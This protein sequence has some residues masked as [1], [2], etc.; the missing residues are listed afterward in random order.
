MSQQE[1]VSPSQSQQS[2][3]EHE[4][5]DNETYHPQHPYYWS[6]N[7][8]G[9]PRD[10]PPSSYDEPMVQ[11]GYQAQDRTEDSKRQQGTTH[12]SRILVPARGYLSPRQGASTFSNDP[13]HDDVVVPLAGTR[14]RQAQRQ[15]FGP[16]GDAYERGYGMDHRYN[17]GRNV[18]PWARAQPK[19][20]NVARLVLFIALGLMLIGPILHLLA[21]LL[22]LVI[23][24]V[25]FA[26]LLAFFVMMII[27]ILSFIF[28]VP[29]RRRSSF[30]PWLGPLGW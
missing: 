18:P 1:F 27:G 16:D 9:V 10:E 13:R 26:L 19:Q 6:P 21:G 11:R 20:K 29:L 24:T 8:A 25:F 12:R 4:L 14:E 22:I 2:Q 7:K 15:Q 28:R 23:G 3:G 5:N 30:P 17:A